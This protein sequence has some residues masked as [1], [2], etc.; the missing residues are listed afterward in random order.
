MCNEVV[1]G[2]GLGALYCEGDRSDDG[3]G[4]GEENGEV[5]GQ[6]QITICNPEKT[7]NPDTT[8]PF[9]ISLAWQLSPPTAEQR[10]A[11]RSAAVEEAMRGVEALEVNFDCVKVRVGRDVTVIRLGGGRRKTDAVGE[12]AD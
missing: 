10:A 4:N 9:H 5:G 8:S 7:N 3:K 2:F 1:R 6:C 12:E 11:L